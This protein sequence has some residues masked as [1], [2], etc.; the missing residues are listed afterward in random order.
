M[1]PQLPQFANAIQGFTDVLCQIR[2]SG[3]LLYSVLKPSSH[4]WSKRMTCGDAYTTVTFPF[5]AKRFDI[6]THDN[7]LNLQRNAVRGDQ[8]DP[9]WD[10]DGGGYYSYN[11][12]TAELQV[13]NSVA[14]TNAD[15]TILIWD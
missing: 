15:I 6:V 5:Q 1:L 13:K 3:A 2:D 7:A 8:Y 14:G 10:V 9:A 4:N 12:W 11:A